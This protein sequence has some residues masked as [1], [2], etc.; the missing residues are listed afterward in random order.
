MD[1]QTLITEILGT[2]LTQTEVAN[3]VKCSQATVSDIARGLQKTTTLDL[4][5][6]ILELHQKVVMKDE[7]RRSPGRRSTDK[8]LGRREVAADLIIKK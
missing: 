1:I 4:G 2:G 5:L 3:T 8:K 7:T 6:R